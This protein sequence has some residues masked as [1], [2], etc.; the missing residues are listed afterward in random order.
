[1]W[2]CG[3]KC[4]ICCILITWLLLVI[5]NNY[6]F[7]NN[8]S[9]FTGRKPS[10]CKGTSSQNMWSL[11]KVDNNPRH[12]P[13]FHHH[14]VGLSSSQSS[15]P[16]SKNVLCGLKQVYHLLRHHQQ[17][18]WNVTSITL[19]SLSVKYQCFDFMCKPRL[20]LVL[21]SY[22]HWLQAWMIPSWTASMWIFIFPF[23]VAL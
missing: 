14:S 13:T 7:Q 20:L 16:S 6:D 3:W 22:L 9:M 15:S 10:I 4:T 19:L 8:F 1:M 18:H 5:W 21:V 2:K 11:E 12:H 23:C 17:Q